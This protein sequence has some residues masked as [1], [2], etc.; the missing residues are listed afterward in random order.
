MMMMMMMMMKILVPQTTVHAHWRSHLFQHD[1]E[2]MRALIASLGVPMSTA[3]PSTSRKCDT[4]NVYCW[5]LLMHAGRRTQNARDCDQGNFACPSCRCVRAGR[6]TH[7][8]AAVDHWPSRL[9]RDRQQ[10]VIREEET[11]S[12]R[13]I[14]PGVLCILAIGPKRADLLPIPTGVPLGERPRPAEDGSSLVLLRAKQKIR[15]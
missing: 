14:I 1:P 12:L 10:L 2:T 4:C 8:R 13:N 11:P 9:G 3:P 15:C 6:R 5:L 7:V